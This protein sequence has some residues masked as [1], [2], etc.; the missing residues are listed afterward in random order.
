MYAPPANHYKKFN[1]SKTD[2]R[3]YMA[4][5]PGL[6]FKPENYSTSI[7]KLIIRSKVFTLKV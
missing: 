4:D 1:K 3:N 5:P 7:F 6:D 2:W